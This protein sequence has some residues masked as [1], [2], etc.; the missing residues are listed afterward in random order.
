MT[1]DAVAP[2]AAILAM[3]AITFVW[4]AAGF[5]L[6]GLVPL[7]PR[8]RRGLEALPGTVI[9]ATVVPLTVQSGLP[10]ALAIG[11]V[12]AARA[13]LRNEFLALAFGVGAAAAA[14]AV[15]L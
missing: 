14:R 5:W 6:M 4:R 12:I 7:T 13:L 2:M 1:A 15:G 9:V 10:A 11:T 8:V 3:T